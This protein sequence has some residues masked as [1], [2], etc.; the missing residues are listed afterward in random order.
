MP[1]PAIFTAM[2]TPFTPDGHLNLDI[3]ARLAQRLAHEGSD[4]LIIAGTTG[5]SPTLTDPE[6]EE[7]FHRVRQAVPHLPLWVG[8]GSNDTAHS[9][10]LA[11]QAEQWG[12]DGI[13][14]VTPYYN[15]PPQE[16]LYRH[17][18]EVAQNVNIPV[19]LYNVPGRTGVHLEADTAARIHAASPN[20]VAIKEA[21]GRLEAF[22]QLRAHAPQ[23]TLY[24]GDDSLLYPSL[25]LG[26]VGVVSVASHVVG[27]E[28][29]ALLRAATSGRHSEAYQR[30]QMLAPIFRDLFAW[31]N[32]IPVKWLLNQLGIDVGPLRPPLVYPSDT[33]GLERLL[34]ETLA[35]QRQRSIRDVSAAEA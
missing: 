28:M 17:F 9:R 35:V 33:R 21:S 13:L 10:H 2:I 8:A 15:K 27:P 4:A 12:A 7:L 34:A 30:E 11:R 19:M 20:V 25:L 23:L 3:A 29:Q 16:G 31:P 24:T 6:R 5:E 1:W 26:A 14:V 22:H 18:V 32:P